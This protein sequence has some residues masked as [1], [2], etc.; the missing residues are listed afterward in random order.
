MS[1][2]EIPE[3]ASPE[4]QVAWKFLQG[5][6]ETNVELAASAL[7]EDLTHEKM[8]P[9]LKEATVRKPAFLKRIKLMSESMS[10]LKVPFL[11]SFS[12]HL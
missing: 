8:L 7:S 2:H 5:V 12:G 9:S 4:L 1:F 3:N 11:T 10:N 6:S